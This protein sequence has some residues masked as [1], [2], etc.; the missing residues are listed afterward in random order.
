MHQL[1]TT[2]NQQAGSLV[3][4]DFKDEI[5]A[6]MIQEETK[7]IDNSTSEDRPCIEGDV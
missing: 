3:K 5:E 6:K 2:I 1:A 7:P 4:E